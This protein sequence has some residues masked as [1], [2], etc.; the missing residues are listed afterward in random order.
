M[1]QMLLEQSKEMR[2][3]NE[4]IYLFSE[5]FWYCLCTQTDVL[6]FL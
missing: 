3:D 1:V 4:G 2:V 5:H 6:M